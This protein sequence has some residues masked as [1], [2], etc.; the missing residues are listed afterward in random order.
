[1]CV[2]IFIETHSGEDS[3]VR[4]DISSWVGTVKKKKIMYYIYNQTNWLP[5]KIPVYYSIIHLEA[6]KEFKGLMKRGHGV[7]GQMF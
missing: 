3:G 5:L 1:M 2:C 7:A 6:C 4:V